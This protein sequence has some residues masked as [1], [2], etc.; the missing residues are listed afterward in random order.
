MVMRW[1]YVNDENTYS[2]ADAMELSYLNATSY[3]FQYGFEKIILKQMNY[4]CKM[5]REIFHQ[6]KNISSYIETNSC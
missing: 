2:Y 6:L 4:E 3:F 1:S 5:E